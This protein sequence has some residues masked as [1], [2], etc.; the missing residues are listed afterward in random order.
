[1]HRIS[2]SAVLRVFELQVFDLGL[3]LIE[4][5]VPE[6]RG[7]AVGGRYVEDPGSMALYV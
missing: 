2:Q 1:M 7:L 3:I 6:S 4:D 5:G